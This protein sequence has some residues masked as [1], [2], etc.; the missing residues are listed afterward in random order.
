MNAKWNPLF[1]ASRFAVPM[2]INVSVWVEAIATV[3]A[4]PNAEPIWYVVLTRPDAI[5]ESSF[6]A[7]ATDAVKAGI[8]ATTFLMQR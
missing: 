7:L 2:S 1:I 3:I 6:F 4:R 8:Y 5:P